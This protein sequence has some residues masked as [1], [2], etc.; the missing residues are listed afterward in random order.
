MKTQPISKLPQGQVTTSV[1]PAGLWVVK[2]RSTEMWYL[3]NRLGSGQASCLVSLA[4]STV[5]GLKK[6]LETTLSF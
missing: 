6:L 2:S 4:E 3:V 1:Q 5:C